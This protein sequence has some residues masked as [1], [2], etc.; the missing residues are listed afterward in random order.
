MVGYDFNT[1]E[2]KEYRGYGVEKAWWTDNDGERIKRYPF[3][4]LVFEG[5]EYIGEQY[6]TLEEAHKFID[7][8]VD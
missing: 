8:I 1:R 3:F 4:Y 6:K 7:S 2:L 5:E